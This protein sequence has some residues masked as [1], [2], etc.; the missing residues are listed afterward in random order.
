MA[1]IGAL[2]V[3]GTAPASVR[4]SFPLDAGPSNGIVMHHFTPIYMGG[5]ATYTEPEAIALAQ[6]FD[7]IAEKAGTFAS[8]ASDMHVANPT[9]KIVAYL[10][11]AFDITPGGTVYPPTWYAHDSN[12]NRIKSIGFGNWLMDPTNPQWAPT[13]ADLCSATLVSTHD[14]GCF[15][16]TLG[17]GPLSRGYVTGVPVD[18]T[19]QQPYTAAKWIAAQTNTIAAVAKVASIVIPNGLADGAQYP[20]TS[21]LLAASDVAMAETWLRVSNDPPTAF[22]STAEWLADV[23]MLTNAESNGWAVMTV[24]KLWT[25]ATAAEV[26]QWHRFTVASF[27]MGAGG[28]SAYNFTAA[29]TVAGMTATNSYDNVAIGTPTDSYALQG[30]VYERSFTNGLA[31]VNPGTSSVTVTLGTTYQNLDGNLVTQETLAPNSGDVLLTNGAPS[32]MTWDFE[33]GTTA[34]WAGGNAT[35]TATGNQPIL[36]PPSLRMTVT[37]NGAAYALSPHP[38]S[39]TE[40]AP[41]RTVTLFMSAEA[42]TVGRYTEAILDWYTADGTYISNTV[43]V[44]ALSS[45]SKWTLYSVIGSA[46]PNAGFYA[47]EYYIG[48]GSFAGEVSFVDFVISS[49]Q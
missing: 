11:G 27:L 7:V 5:R 14:D 8:Y 35:L 13:V 4:A 49:V 20:Q 17:V 40:V 47:A 31:I 18:P 48:D 37:E 26:D 30:G 36:A 1:S 34:N 32:R 25:A 16:D 44:A 41:G 28:N 46:P 22:P 42:G 38:F 15:L 24:T 3:T 10:N 43:G 2:V 9:L 6:Q 33:D 29:K 39:G 12:G 23:N 19:T 45:T 21:P